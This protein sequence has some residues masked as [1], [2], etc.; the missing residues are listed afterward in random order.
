MLVSLIRQRYDCPHREITPKQISAVSHFYSPICTPNTL[1]GRT[2]YEFANIKL[3]RPLPKL[4][5]PIMAYLHAPGSGRVQK[6]PQGAREPQSDIL[7]L[8]PARFSVKRH[9]TRFSVNISLILT[10]HRKP[11]FSEPSATADVGLAAS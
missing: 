10:R 8:L 6:P 2:G 3:H 7:A 9:Q 1:L 4:E 5:V 11:G